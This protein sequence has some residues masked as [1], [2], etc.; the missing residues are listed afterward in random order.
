MGGVAAG[1]VVGGKYR[2]EAPIGRGGMASV[3]RA[4]HTTL[5]HSLAVKLLETFGTAREKMA[6]R[7]L[8][9]AKLAAGLQHRNVV[10]ILDYGVMDDGQP[11]MAMELLEGT[12]LQDRFDNG[13]PLS[14]VELLDIVASV[15]SGLAVVHDAGIVHRDI[16]PDNIFL[17]R[18]PDGDY[19]KLLDFGISRGVEGDGLD[20]RVTNTGAVVGTP[21][22]MSPEQ[23]RGVKDLDHRTDLWSVGIMLYEGLTGDVPFIAE[24]MGDVLIQVATTDAPSLAEARPDLPDEIVSVVDRALIRDRSK[25]WNDARSL[26]AAV[27]AAKEALKNGTGTPRQ[28]A[29]V[30][31]SMS[32]A[33]APTTGEVPAVPSSPSRWPLVAA[34]AVVALLGAVA[35]AFIALGGEI[36]FTGAAPETEPTAAPPA[37]AQAAPPAVLPAPELHVASAPEAAGGL[38]VQA[39]APESAPVTATEP[40]TAEQPAP[41]TARNTPRRAPEPAPRPLAPAEERAAPRPAQNTEPAPRPA[42]PRQRSGGGFLRDL[43]Y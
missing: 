40:V 26:R 31:R 5:E 29:L 24:N 34:G 1:T 32:P 7:F 37:E 28:R 3:W 9:E 4:T 18:D 16:K 13:P 21:Y 43:D 15:L 39:N 36:R 42:Q 25:R 14:P 33:P 10:H 12:N 30:T 2:L 6:K 11:F 23:A 17:V 19:P 22:Y 38:E 27:L 35:I 8:R 20:A 41:R